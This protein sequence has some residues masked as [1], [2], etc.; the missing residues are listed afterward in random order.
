MNRELFYWY[1][2]HYWDIFMDMTLTGKSMVLWAVFTIFFLVVRFASVAYWKVDRTI[3]ASYDILSKGH[4]FLFIRRKKRN[5]IEEKAHRTAYNLYPKE[6]KIYKIRCWVSNS[7]I[8]TAVITGLPFMLKLAFF[9]LQVSFFVISLWVG[10]NSDINKPELQFVK[11]HAVQSYIRSD[12]IK[13]NGYWRGGEGGYFRT[14]PDGIL[15][16]NLGN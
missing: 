6:Y 12:G 10:L 8:I 3:R 16:N 14:S 5:S 2:S 9:A 11:P 7:F 1:V 13:V 4:I 15:E